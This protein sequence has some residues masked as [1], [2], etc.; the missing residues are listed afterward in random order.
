[1]AMWR[2]LT[3]CV[4]LLFAAM[5][6]ATEPTVLQVTIA[7]RK[8]TTETT[9]RVTEGAVV[10]LRWTADE[11]VELHLHGYEIAIQVPPGGSA[12]MDFT[13]DVTGRFP[14]SHHG[15]GA[16]MGQLH[17]QRPIVYLEVLPK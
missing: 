7:D 6:R 8:V 5:A 12:A 16:E 9:L 13:A 15:F 4:L 11:A 1:M 17:S 3:V 2:V 14:I 10:E